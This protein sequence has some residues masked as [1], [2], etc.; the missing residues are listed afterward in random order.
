MDAIRTVLWISGLLAIATFIGMLV[1]APMPGGGRNGRGAAAM[2]V[3]AE[4][5]GGRIRRAMGEGRHAAAVSIAAQTVEQF[6]DDPEAWLW[7]VR[8]QHALGHEAGARA[9]G[10]RLLRATEAGPIPGGVLEQGVRASRLGWAYW[11]LSRQEIAREHFMDAANLFG[12]TPM[13]LLDE[14]QR[15]YALAGFL[16]MGGRPERAAEHFAL[17]VDAN[18]RGDGGWWKVDPALASIRGQR[19]YL[20]AGV[21]LQRREEERERRRME[22]MN[23]PGPVSPATPDNPAAGVGEPIP[24]PHGA[25]SRVPDGGP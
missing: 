11:V 9:A 7:Q 20:D 15:Q 18:Y 14:G 25:R 1:Y 17:A 4:E 5:Q 2:P 23:P 8:V 13:G 22:R 6:P 12:L 10:E 16:A 21:V 19:A 24:M 3:S